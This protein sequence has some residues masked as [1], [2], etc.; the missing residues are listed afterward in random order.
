MEHH[1]QNGQILL[2]GQSEA[3]SHSEIKSGAT[4]RFP[5]TK[6]ALEATNWNLLTFLSLPAK[7]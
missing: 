3:L 5:D 6:L 2:I 1:W 4:A 7:D